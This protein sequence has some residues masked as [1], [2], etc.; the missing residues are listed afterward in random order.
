MREEEGEGRCEQPRFP[1][2]SPKW[3]QIGGNGM[4]QRLLEW[5]RSEEND[6]YSGPVDSLELGTY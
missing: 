1:T 4:G 3:I 6:I 2:I 5:R